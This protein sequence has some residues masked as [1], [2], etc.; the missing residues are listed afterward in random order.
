MHAC[1]FL[2]IQSVWRNYKD[3]RKLNTLTNPKVY[4]KLLFAS[5]P[6]GMQNRECNH[7]KLLS[8]VCFV[9]NLRKDYRAKANEKKKEKKPV[10]FFWFSL[11]NK[12]KSLGREEKIALLSH[13]PKASL[14][15]LCTTQ[16]FH[17]SLSAKHKSFAPLSAQHKC[18]TLSSKH[19]SFT[20]LSAQHK[21]STLPS[22]HNPKAS[23][24]HS[25]LSGRGKWQ[26]GHCFTLVTMT[27]ENE[28]FL[29]LGKRAE[30]K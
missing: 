30:Q 24:F 10:F 29:L 23:L 26:A 7:C 15:S 13:E 3:L 17:S 1:I 25:S 27:V 18:S 6:V 22:L 5:D 14:F 16:K 20:P 11:K 4:K 21:T 2:Q 19:K 28:E 8:F 9:S 12:A